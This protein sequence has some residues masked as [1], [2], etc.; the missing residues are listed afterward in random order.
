MVRSGRLGRTRLVVR[1]RRSSSSGPSRCR[2]DL[3]GVMEFVRRATDESNAPYQAAENVID[4]DGMR[5]MFPRASDRLLIDDV[6]AGGDPLLD[7]A[8]DVRRGREK[9]RIR[10][11]KFRLPGEHRPVGKIVERGVFRIRGQESLQIPPVVGVDL[12]LNDFFG[13]FTH[14]ARRLFQ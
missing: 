10:A 9:M 7:S 14:V 1:T 6:V 4:R 5:G 13:S 8:K 11:T 2:G 3:N 12:A